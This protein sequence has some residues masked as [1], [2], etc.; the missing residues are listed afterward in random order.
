MPQRH[1]LAL[2][3]TGERYAVASRG[4][5]A[6]EGEWVW[7]WKDWIDRRWMR[8]Y[9]EPPMSIEGRRSRDDS[10][11]LS[12][13]EPQLLPLDFAAMR[14]GGCGAKVGSTVLRR[15]LQ[16]LKVTA[17]EDILIGL[18]APDDAA[19]ICG[20][21]RYPFRFTC[22][23]ARD[24]IFAVQFHPEKS[25]AAGLALLRN[26]STWDGRAPALD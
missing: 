11:E 22:A 24:N 18:E 20:T 5:F 8:K 1:H 21:S 26:F 17:R 16:R 4:P 23:V 15:V 9:Q 19:V 10:A 25:Q 2:I 12:R 7:R 3:S 14:C 13:V 6:F